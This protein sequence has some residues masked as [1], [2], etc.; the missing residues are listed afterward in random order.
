MLANLLSR[1]ADSCGGSASVEGQSFCTGLPKSAASSGNLQHILTIV[2]STLA[3]V[4]VLMVVL[5]GLKFV[6][7]GDEPQEVAK[8]RNNVI[9]ALVGL[10]IVVSA[11]VIVTFVIGKI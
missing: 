5:A 8:A 3:V 4:A 9:Y 1:F 10:A 2:F 7:S 6:T 11:D